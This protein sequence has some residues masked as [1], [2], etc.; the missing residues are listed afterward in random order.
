MGYP[1][2]I[3]I[4]DLLTGCAQL[5]N[6][7]ADLDRVPNHDR[8]RQQPQTA[9]LIHNLLAITDAK[10]AAVSEEQITGLVQC[11]ASPRRIG[12]A[13]S[14]FPKIVALL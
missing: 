13:K 2:Q 12:V 9:R 11:R 7:I 5:A 8:L 14:F 6:D 4:I 1:R 3:S 10:F